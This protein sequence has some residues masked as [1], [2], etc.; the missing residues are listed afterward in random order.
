[1]E[2]DEGPSVN[3]GPSEAHTRP[4]QASTGTDGKDSFREESPDFPRPLVS[5]LKPR[6][7]HPRAPAKAPS[8]AR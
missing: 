3:E 5:S 7:K 1:M 2:L 8:V 4:S 6:A